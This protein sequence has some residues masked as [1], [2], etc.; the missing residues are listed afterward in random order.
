MSWLQLS[1]APSR[2]AASLQT[3]RKRASCSTR[4]PGSCRGT[5]QRGGG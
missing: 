4:A 1:T 3:P 2:A 5:G